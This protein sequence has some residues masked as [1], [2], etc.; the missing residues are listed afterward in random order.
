MCG[1]GRRGGRGVRG[2][3]HLRVDVVLFDAFIY[4]NLFYGCDNVE[5]LL[6]AFFF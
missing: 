3:C 1:R 5:D 6:Y 2:A 4:F